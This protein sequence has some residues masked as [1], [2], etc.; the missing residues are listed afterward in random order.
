MSKVLA[1]SR[2]SRPFSPKC[3]EGV[4]PTPVFQIKSMTRREWFKL[5][6]EQNANVPKCVSKEGEVDASAV[7]EKIWDTLIQGI[8]MNNKL[9]EKHLTGWEHVMDEC[10]EDLPF[11]KDNFELL[12][13]AVISE[14]IKEITGQVTKEEAKN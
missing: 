4:S 7:D 2:R 10:N 6:A 8:D 14:L 3:Y 9:F 12:P 13:D 5:L 1:L 11:G